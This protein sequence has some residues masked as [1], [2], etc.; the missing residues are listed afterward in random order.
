[1]LAI[2]QQVRARVGMGESVHL[3]K[4]LSRHLT[5]R[6]TVSVADLLQSGADLISSVGNDFIKAP[7]PGLR[8]FD[9]CFSPI[10]LSSTL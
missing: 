5:P 4:C 2:T 7:P 10:N 8:A 1:M 9:T 3:S 6:C